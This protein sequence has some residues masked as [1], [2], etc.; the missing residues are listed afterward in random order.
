M[1]LVTAAAT[2]S[3]DTRYAL[4]DTH[5]QTLGLGGEQE[6]KKKKKK[7]KRKRERER[8]MVERLRLGKERATDSRKS[9]VFLSEGIHVECGA[10]THTNA[11]MYGVS[12][13][14]APS[15]TTLRALARAKKKK[16]RKK[17]RATVLVR[18]KELAG[19]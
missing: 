8:K 14:P 9:G 17:V 18:A 19:V 5:L 13:M 7:R 4:S 2:F 11:R 15:V 6:G 16:K 12:H 10:R 1:P 3:G